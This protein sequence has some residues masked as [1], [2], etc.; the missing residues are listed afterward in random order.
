MLGSFGSQLLFPI[1]SSKISILVHF[2]KGSH[3]PTPNWLHLAIYC[4]WTS[5]NVSSQFC[6]G[7]IL[8]RFQKPRNRHSWLWEERVLAWMQD[9]LTD[10]QRWRKFVYTRLTLLITKYDY[11]IVRT[12][13]LL[14]FI[15]RRGGTPTAPT[16]PTAGRRAGR[17]AGRSFGIT[18][19]EGAKVGAVAGG[20]LGSGTARP[21]EIVKSVPDTKNSFVKQTS[22]KRS[23]WF[24]CV[25][26]CEC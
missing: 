21:G 19:P 3:Q 20:T 13:S 10:A 8:H 17:T 15:K 24:P 16:A 18:D 11:R 26:V 14:F 6:H 12:I 25:N 22:A 23:L 7:D 1:F 9:R 2:E 5:N 4:P